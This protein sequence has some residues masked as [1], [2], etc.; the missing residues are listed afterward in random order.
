MVGKRRLGPTNNNNPRQEECAINDSVASVTTL[1]GKRALVIDDMG[2]AVAI[3]RNMLLQLGARQVD[4]AQDYQSAFKQLVQRTYDLVLC[5]FNLGN[6]LNGQQLLRDLRHIQRL[7]YTTLFVVVSAERTKDIVLGTI[8]C[9]PDGY[10]AKPFT[11]GDF[12]NRIARLMEV[13]R[14]FRE[15]NEAMDGKSY[16]TAFALGEQIINNQPQ[17]RSQALRKTAGML[18]EQKRFP[19]ALELFERE[20]EKRDQ[21]WARIGRAR[22]IA[23]MGDTGRAIAE[24]EDIIQAHPLAIAAIE[25]MAICMLREGRKRDAQ[26]ALIKSLELSP[27]STDRQRWLG[28]LSMDIGEMGTALKAYKAVIKLADGTLKETRKQH[29]TYVKAIRKAV[30][31]EGDAKI[32]AEMIAEGRAHVKF[33]MKKF[34][35]HTELLNYNASMFRALEKFNQDKAEEAIAIIDA[36]IQRHK[37]ALAADPEMV[38]DVAEAKFFAGDRPGAEVLLRKLIKDNEDNKALVERIRA[39][40]DTPVPYYKRVFITEMNR[41]GKQQY[42]QGDFDG[43]LQSFRQALN[44]YPQHPAI[45]LNAVQATLKLIDAGKRSSSALVEAKKYLDNSV[46]L[47]PEHPEFNRKQAFSRYMEKAL[48]KA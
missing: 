20:L 1:D 8:E 10:I 27:M 30:E 19:E 13:Q 6:G 45:N 25:S 24:F 2:A 41:K 34:E 44:E 42:D 23:E 32:R 46:A 38:I 26:E 5:D 33:A 43:A 7:S 39:I 48:K 17:Y 21:A 4:T 12:K 29:E 28:D 35:T 16:E 3:A 36:T 37:D 18:Y 11:Q 22:C 47:E 9:E 31:S 15:F 14:T 40:I